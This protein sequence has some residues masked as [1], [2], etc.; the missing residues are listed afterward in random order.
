MNRLII[1][2]GA[3][4][5]LREEP[6]IIPDAAVVVEDGI[7]VD[8]IKEKRF[9]HP[10]S[11]IL[12]ARGAAV[13]PGL[14]NAH[15]HLYQALLRALWDNMP[16]V[17]WLK[18][19]YQ[20]APVLEPEDLY[21]GAEVGLLEA[22]KGGVTTVCDHHFLN[23]TFQHTA[24]TIE[25]MLRSGVRA[26]LVR[27]V[28]D[29]G[30]LVPDCVLEPSDKALGELD[31]LMGS[32]EGAI[33]SGM[34]RIMAGPNTPCLNASTGLIKAIH[35][36]CE[37]RGLRISAHVAESK[38]I[39]DLAK[40]KYGYGG[41]VEYLESVGMIQPYV[42]LAHCVHV[43]EDE[44]DILAQVGAAVVHNPVSN[45]ILGDGIA[46]VAEMLHAGINVAL[47]TDGAASNHTQDMFEVMKLCSL[48]QRVRN[49]D[50]AVIGPYRVLRMATYGGAKALGLEDLIGTIE[51][52]KQADLVTV[53]LHTSPHNV[54][55]HDL[56][57]HLVHS[58]KA[59]DVSNVIVS[60]RVVMRDRKVLTLKEDEV[61][62]A[63]QHRATDLVARVRSQKYLS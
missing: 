24:A 15:T 53:D 32:Y 42:A 63:A 18:N 13:I 9:Y 10:Q 6:E 7:I 43:S 30:D 33:A 25:A 47:G 2:N 8:I 55:I 38:E 54:G 21:L 40:Q 27:A 19:I 37:H 45:C 34:L 44:I 23:P 17:A 29:E 49:N 4:F 61:L 39:V 57:S 48:L 31:K 26:I 36:F 52:G 5:P 62:K 35:Q 11:E 50:P 51:V 56:F 1:Q 41:V 12:D 3:V 20:V 22:I 16:L 14:V 28:M 58:A 46:P 59:V 60:G